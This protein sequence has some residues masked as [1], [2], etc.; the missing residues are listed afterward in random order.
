MNTHYEYIL[1]CFP[2]RIKEI[3]E[4]YNIISSANNLG[5]T[6]LIHRNYD[7]DSIMIIKECLNGIYCHKL[8]QFNQQLISF[9]RMIKSK[10]LISISQIITKEH[11]KTGRSNKQTLIILVN[12]FEKIL[13]DEQIQYFKYL[14]SFCALHNIII[15][16][17]YFSYNPLST[18]LGYHYKRIVFLPL[19]LESIQHVISMSIQTTNVDIKKKIMIFVEKLYW[20]NPSRLFIITSSFSF[21][22]YLHSNPNATDNSLNSFF[23][24]I[25]QPL[26]IGHKLI[27][28]NIDLI[29]NTS[30]HLNYLLYISFKLSLNNSC[31]LKIN[32]IYSEYTFSCPN[33][34]PFD[35]F[36]LLFKSAVDDHYF[37]AA[38]T[39]VPF[40]VNSYK[41]IITQNQ[42]D[43]IEDSIFGH[44]KLETDAF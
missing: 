6:I 29:N 40:I 30:Y 23:N 31:S 1:S 15:H 4:F 16:L 12:D 43:Q 13:K 20:Y 33:P 38:Q 36:I 37:I 22:E 8:I 41:L 14:Q 44:Q 5:E 17:V 25:I 26:C 28:E 3:N 19:S 10:P 34:L 24:T 9:I 11:I 39:D 21:F 18:Q 35:M 2:E 7:D 42:F 27:K 32:K